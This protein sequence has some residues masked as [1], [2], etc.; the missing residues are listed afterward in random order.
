VRPSPGRK[1]T[2]TAIT[3]SFLTLNK[4]I[5]DMHHVLRAETKA[6]AATIQ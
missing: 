2:H 5:E 6:Q 3:I 1:G 4:R